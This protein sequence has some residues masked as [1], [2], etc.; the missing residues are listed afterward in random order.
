L[1]IESDHSAVDIAPTEM[2]LREGRPMKDDDALTEQR[3][4]LRG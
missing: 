1:R 3:Q 4:D 2:R